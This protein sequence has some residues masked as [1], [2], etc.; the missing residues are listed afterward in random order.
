MLKRNR[1]TALLL[2]G[3]MGTATMVSPLTAFDAQ[4][5]YTYAKVDG[6]YRMIDGTVINGVVARGIDVS[7]W[8]GV[9]DWPAVRCV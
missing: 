9:I 8:K 1:W 5:A 7:H 3:V 6:A 4:A 2:A